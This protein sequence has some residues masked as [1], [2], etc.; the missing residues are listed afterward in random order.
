MEQRTK[1]AARVQ[2]G[3]APHPKES[4]LKVKKTKSVASSS[5]SPAVKSGEQMQRSASV[6]QQQQA[7]PNAM[8]P[9]T[10][11]HSAS[12]ESQQKKLKKRIQKTTIKTTTTPGGEMPQQRQTSIDPEGAPPSHGN[13]KSK[14]EHSLNHTYKH[15]R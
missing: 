4:T 12:S 11:K 7:G 15:K 3:D 14:P 2:R 6:A 9:P 5:M 10:L 1:E 8:G 13:L